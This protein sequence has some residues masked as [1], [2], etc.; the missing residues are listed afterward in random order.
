MI[1]VYYPVDVLVHGNQFDE[2]RMVSGQEWALMLGQ[3]VTFAPPLVVQLVVLDEVESGQ[4][5]SAV[6]NRAHSL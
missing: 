4:F 3:G 1:L 2:A 5:D 6:L